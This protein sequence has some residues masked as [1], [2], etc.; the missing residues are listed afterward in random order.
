M[1][2]N[3]EYVKQEG[4]GWERKDQ[5]MKLRDYPVVMMGTL[6]R[7]STD[8]GIL[9]HSNRKATRMANENRQNPSR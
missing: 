4:A 5:T 9:T 8:T 6:H 7:I 1:S 2:Q 3:E